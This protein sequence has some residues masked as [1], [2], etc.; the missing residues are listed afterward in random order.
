LSGEVH[1]VASKLPRTPSAAPSEQMV[2]FLQYVTTYGFSLEKV[3]II[4]AWVRKAIVG[5]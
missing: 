2:M 5:C 4:L 1:A 3:L